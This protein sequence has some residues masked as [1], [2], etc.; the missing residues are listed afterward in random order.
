MNRS[1]DIGAIVHAFAQQ[2]S[3]R[4]LAEGVQE[5]YRFHPGL[6]KGRGMSLASEAGR[7]RGANLA[8]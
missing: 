8:A 5:Y 6:A 1:I 3:P 2:D 7:E 4:T